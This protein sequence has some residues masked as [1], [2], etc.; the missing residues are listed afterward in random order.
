MTDKTK[1]HSP[2]SISS[3]SDTNVGRQR[4]GLRLIKNEQPSQDVINDIKSGA[5]KLTSVSETRPKSKMF[6]QFSKLA[7]AID[8]EVDMILKL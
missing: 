3:S 4:V 5:P 2:T 1:R 7:D 6:L 8:A